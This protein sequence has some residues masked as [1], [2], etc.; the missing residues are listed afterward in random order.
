M[1][2][3]DKANRYTRGQVVSED[4]SQNVVAVCGVVLPKMKQ[5]HEEPVGWQGCHVILLIYKSAVC[6]SDSV[7]WWMVFKMQS[8]PLFLD[9]FEGFNFGGFDLSEPA[10]TCYSG[11]FSKSG[12]VGRS[13]WLRQNHPG[14]MPRCY[15]WPCQIP[16]NSQSSI[17]R[18]NG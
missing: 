8:F 4:L 10:E 1:W 18:S 11:G 2:R 6:C 17:R 15:D 16:G 13:H 5:L 14:G 3:K 12:A 7:W 9:V